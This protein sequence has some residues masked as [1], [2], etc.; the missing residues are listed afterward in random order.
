MMT[1]SELVAAKKFLRAKMLDARDAMS[2]AMRN[3]AA[4]A[5]TVRLCQMPEYR[6]ASTV[7]NYMSF[8][9]ELDTHAFFDRVLS[10]GK[11]P[12]LPRID[13]PTKSL[14]LH[15]VEGHADLV[16]GV[17]GIREPRADAPMLAIDAIDMVLMPGLAFD[18]SGNRLGYGAGFYDRLLSRSAEKPFRIVAAFDCQIVDAVPADA[19]DRPCHGIVTESQLLR[20]PA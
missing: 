15:R 1:K 5:I 18:R 13:K 2:P 14:S 6:Q 8:G 12:V 9:T 20:I 4:A 11:I 3:A 19:H 17:W 7:L 16:D 10:D